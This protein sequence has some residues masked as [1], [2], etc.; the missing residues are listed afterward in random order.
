M[1]SGWRE[2][3][4]KGPAEQRTNNPGCS[5]AERQPYEVGSAQLV[6]TAGWLFAGAAQTESV[7]HIVKAYPTARA[8]SAVASFRGAVEACRQWNEGG[9]D[10]SGYAFAMTFESV[11]AP[12]FGDEAFAWLESARTELSPEVATSYSVMVRVGDMVTT[13]R[14]TPGTLTPRAT[15]LERLTAYAAIAV[16]K[17]RAA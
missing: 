13:V 1:G 6:V 11:S 14:Y 16:A 7:H 4:A 3:P 9:V 17:V 12:A 8:A 10:P 15:G 5:S 2:Q